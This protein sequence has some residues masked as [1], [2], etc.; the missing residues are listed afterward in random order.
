MPTEKRLEI[1]TPPG[2]KDYELLDSGLGLKLERF[3]PYR[4]V[5]P[6]AQAIWKPS[7][8]Q[9]HWR[10]ADGTFRGPNDKESKWSF[11]KPIEPRWVMS[12]GDLKFWVQPTAFRH[13]GVFPEQ[14][15]HWDW[16]AALI[17]GAKRE[18]KVLNLFGYTGIATL[19]A[20]AAGAH[21]AHVDAS[22]KVVQ[23]AS[24]NHGL[25]GLKGR[26][27]RWIV[28]DV[29]KYVK[30]EGRRG[31]HYDG[32]IVDPPKHGRGPAGEIW[33]IE[34]SLPS[35]LEE[36][37]ALLSDS[38]LFFVLTCYATQL[39]TVTVRNVVE[40]L[41]RGMGGRLT[42]GEL[43]NVEKTRGRLLSTAMFVR[44]SSMPAEEAP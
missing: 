31:V 40:D 26:P 14:A 17:R 12:Y 28:D 13:L 2:W 33:Q 38:P 36:C 30:R 6:E 25:S 35:L 41:V 11:P 7:L 29:I 24:E 1:L 34:T 37:R 21:V 20:S 4:F 23:W 43:A 15:S 3:G 5:R 32:I 16:M 8:S 42:A 10:S 9:E 39:S 18:V 27:V 19:A 22:K 44:W